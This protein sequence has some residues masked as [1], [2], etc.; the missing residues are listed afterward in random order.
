MTY[1]M[2]DDIQGLGYYVDRAIDYLGEAGDW[3]LE[4]PATNFD[5]LAGSQSAFCAGVAMHRHAGRPFAGIKEADAK[6]GIDRA[7]DF[8]LWN[9]LKIGATIVSSTGSR[10][11]V[12]V[13]EYARFK[14]LLPVSVI[15]CTRNSEV[16][17]RMGREIHEIPVPGKEP[18]SYL[19]EDILEPP[20]VNTVTYGR[21]LQGVTHEDISLIDQEVRNLPRPPGGGY[22]RYRAFSFLLPDDMP[23]IAEMVDWKFNEIFGRRVPA[24]ATY[25]TNFMHGGGINDAEDELYVSFGVDNPYF[26]KPENRHVIE[27]PDDRKRFGPAGFLFACYKAIGQMQADMGDTGFQDRVMDYHRVN[28]TRTWNVPVGIT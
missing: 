3:T 17:Q 1:V 28:K 23:D 16:A 18:G 6:G 11:I 24:R 15:T 10:N 7:K 22:S 21:M 12:P 9:G 25:W 2:A 4:F 13:A 19:T 20:T 5:V 14:A 26:G 27:L 8:F